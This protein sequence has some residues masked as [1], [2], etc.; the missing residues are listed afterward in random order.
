[1]YNICMQ[2]L[3]A[4]ITAPVAQRNQGNQGN[5]IK[6]LKKMEEREQI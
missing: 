1:M 3:P 2:L 6:E 5:E 4:R